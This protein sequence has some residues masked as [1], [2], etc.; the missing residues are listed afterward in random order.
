MV[1]ILLQAKARINDY[2]ER[3]YDGKFDEHQGS[4]IRV[5]CYMSNADINVKGKRPYVE[6]EEHL[7]LVHFFFFFS[8]FRVDV[9]S[10]E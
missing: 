10:A 8:L 2:G 3:F 6:P 1:Q 9:K 4:T 5:M 7:I